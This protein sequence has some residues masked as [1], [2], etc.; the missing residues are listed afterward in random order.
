M[1]TTVYLY[2]KDAREFYGITEPQV[3]D[4]SLAHLPAGYDEA[5]APDDFP[6]A[7]DYA[8]SYYG[9]R[10]LRTNDALMAWTN[11]LNLARDETERE[12]VY[13]H[14]A[15]I[16]ISIGQYAEA[17]AHL[18]AVT[19]DALADMR[20][21]LERNLANSQHPKT[22]VVAEIPT[23]NVVAPA[24]RLPL[25]TNGLPALTNP[26]VFPPKV[27]A[28]MSNVPPV[29]PKASGFAGR[30]AAVARTKTVMDWTKSYALSL[31][32]SLW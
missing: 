8:Q 31:F 4:K 15:R 13:L 22:N 27:V 23:N 28:V 26:P 20:K 17:T 10:P 19:N 12:G 18:N 24:N 21:R 16:K 3:F 6:L 2:R 14:L 7:T 30:V 11:A 25:L 29:A 32:P 1:A 9:I 5:R